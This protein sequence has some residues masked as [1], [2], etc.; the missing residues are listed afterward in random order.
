MADNGMPLLSY[1]EE[2]V[3]KYFSSETR[4]SAMVLGCGAGLTSN[5]LT[6]TFETVCARH[7]LSVG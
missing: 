5:L 7:L 2:V 6:K 4:K 3:A 1:V